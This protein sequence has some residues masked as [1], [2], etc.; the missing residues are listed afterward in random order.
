MPSVTILLLKYSFK[1]LF[2]PL[3]A[4]QAI[5][6][7]ASQR[8]SQSTSISLVDRS[9]GL[10][11]YTTVDLKH[12][13]PTVPVNHTLLPGSDSLTMGPTTPSQPNATFGL[14]TP[15]NM[16]RPSSFVFQGRLRLN[17]SILSPE[18]SLPLLCTLLFSS[19][20]SFR[21]SPY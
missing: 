15:A 3:P 6:L 13:P 16:V 14:S 2:T 1:I 12:N 8:V 21:S 19:H 11:G 4:Y 5:K 17:S 18:L 20:N 9:Y 7:P 10:V